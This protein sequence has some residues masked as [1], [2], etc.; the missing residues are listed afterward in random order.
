MAPTTAAATTIIGDGADVGD[1]IGN[2]STTN[3]NYDYPKGKGVDHPK[4]APAAKFDEQAKYLEDEDRPFFVLVGKGGVIDALEK[5]DRQL[6]NVRRPVV[7]TCTPIQSLLGWPEPCH[8]Q[9]APHRLDRE[10]GQSGST[11]IDQPWR[12]SQDSD[13]PREVPWISA[14]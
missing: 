9:E 6:L 14:S 11:G 3:G 1:R 2:G 5:L 12:S 10:R 13:S 4:G 8:L 7:R